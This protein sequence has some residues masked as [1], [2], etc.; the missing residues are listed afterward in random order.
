MK[1]ITGRDFDIDGYLHQTKLQP[2]ALFRKGALKGVE[3][4]AI[5]I[6]VSNAGLNDLGAQ[7]RDAIQFLKQNREALAALKAFKGVELLS[8]DFTVVDQTGKAQHYVFPAEL[9]YYTGSS[10]IGIE[11]ALI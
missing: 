6:T 10:G 1:E 5:H 4:S 8:L 11:L 9:L 7:I 2:S 3:K